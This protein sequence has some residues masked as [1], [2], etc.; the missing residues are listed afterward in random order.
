MS[1]VKGKKVVIEA[2]NLH[3]SRGSSPNSSAAAA[4]QDGG[5]R[6]HTDQYKA[7]PDAAKQVSVLVAATC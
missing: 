2:V 1:V 6:Q 3:N 5:G 4:Q 7:T